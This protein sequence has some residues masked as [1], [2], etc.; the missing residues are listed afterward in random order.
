M[1]F[2]DIQ[3]VDQ[4]LQQESQLQDENQIQQDTDASLPVIDLDAAEQQDPPTKSQQLYRNLLNIKNQDGSSKY[5]KDV[6][7][8]EDEFSTA[9]SDSAKADNIYSKLV[10]DGFTVEDIGDK[11]EF[12]NT[13]VVKKKYGGLPSPTGAQVDANGLPIA[14]LKSASA[15]PGV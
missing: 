4:P 7:G 12:L 14:P 5:T 15:L 11:N 9:L 1:A 6:L 8:S 10:S 2:E 13:F 3:N